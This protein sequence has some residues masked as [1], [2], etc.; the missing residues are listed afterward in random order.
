LE[1]GDILRKVYDALF[2]RPMNFSFVDEHVSGSARIMSKHDVEWLEGRGI[3]AII[4]LTENPIP[5]SWLDS[6]LDYRH[7]PVK[8]HRAPTQSQIEKCVDFILSNIE[9]G[10]KTAAHCAA[11]K[12]RTGTILAA[13]VC[14]HDGL[15][16]ESAIARVRAKR[17]GSVEKNPK[18]GQEDAVIEYGKTLREKKF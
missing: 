11:G 5:N 4:S 9:K 7:V 2:H 10:K 15:S 14:S 1:A 13:Y 12:G 3:G 6:H 17:P 8:N 18:S 16:A